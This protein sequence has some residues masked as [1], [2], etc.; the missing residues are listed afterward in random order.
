MMRRWLPGL[1]VVALAAMPAA[2][3]API[4]LYPRTAPVTAAP[5]QPAPPQPALSQ[6]AAPV[7]PPLAGPSEQPA[8]A[9]RGI[10]VTPLP[11]PG[12]SP[13]SPPPPAVSAPAPAPSRP[14]PPATPGDAALTAIEG[15][16]GALAQGDGALANTFLM[17]E[18]RNQGAY[19]SAAMSRFYGE[20]REPLQLLGIGRLDPDVLRVRYA[21]THQ[22]GRRC[23]GVADVTVR[24]ADGQALIER[25]RALSG[26]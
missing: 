26:C 18:K 4:Q 16:Y 21:Y 1:A 7:V 24:Y 9:P 22:S 25:I 12:G 11:G 2:A 10:E 3:Q 20:M 8:T 13:S 17:P 14:A 19:E 6:P 5:L 23:D 15:F